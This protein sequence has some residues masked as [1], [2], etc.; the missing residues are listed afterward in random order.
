MQNDEK[1]SKLLE[2]GGVVRWSGTP[3]P[4]GLFDETHKTSTMIS[5]FWALLWGIILVG[6][7]YASAVKTG[8]EI[9]KGIMAFCAVIPI[10]VAWGPIRDK[11]NIKKMLYALTD[12]RA[13]VISSDENNSLTMNITDIDGVRVEKTNNGNCHIRLGSPVFKASARKLLGL[14]YRG[15]FETEDNN[16]IYKGLVFYNVSAK[17]GDMIRG[18]F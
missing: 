13:I 2:K 7:Y 9:Q 18:L 10:A 12:K 5:L 11:S 6:G 3:Q 17:D 1:L 14:A 16:K 8:Q 4:Y 15:E